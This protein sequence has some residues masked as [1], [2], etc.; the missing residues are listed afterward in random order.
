D[1]LFA[2]HGAMVSEQAATRLGLGL[3]TSI[4]LGQG[5]LEVVGIYA[6]Y[7]NPKGQVMLSRERLTADFP[8]ARRAGTG[9]R[10]APEEVGPVLTR[11]TETFQI[12]PEN[13]ID[14]TALK[15]LARGTFERT[16]AITAALNVLT[17]MIA[18]V[19]LFTSLLTLVERRIAA[20]APVWAVGIA[21]RRLAVI[22][23]GKTLLLAGLTA[24]M[25][26]PVGLVLAWLLVSVINV[27]AFGWRLPL[28][29]FPDQWL[30]LGVLSIAMAAV[31][32][33]LPMLSLARTAPTRLLK[34]FS[35]AR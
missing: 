32:A 11:L 33:F 13:V 5:R 24:V 10:L 19:A 22:E 14:Q 6:D 35:H 3:G 30:T 31:A 1:S 20:L 25:A 9:L 16:F 29:P 7:G 8:T 4:D 27:K 12:P 21:R 26:I 17:M 2:G 34:V 18:S 28:V 23:M 15:S